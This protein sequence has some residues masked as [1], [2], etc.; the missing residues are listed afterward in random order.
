VTTAQEIRARVAHADQARIEQRSNAAAAVYEFAERRDR[1]RAELAQ[2]E[3]Q[4]TV[5]VTAAS[6]VMTVQELGEF[7]G[8]PS[9]E[10]NH[11]LAMTTGRR[12]PRTADT[13]RRRA[14]KPQQPAP[15]PSGSA[16]RSSGSSSGP[17]Q[18]GAVFT[19]AT[20]VG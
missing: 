10:V 2:V 13:S 5:A 3:Q 20:S 12:S 14:S 15:A 8:R 6:A 4:L 18:D 11:W 19:P 1:L 16:P 7:I 17:G 9:R